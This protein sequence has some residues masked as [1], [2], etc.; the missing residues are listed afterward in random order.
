MMKKEKEEEEGC[1]SICPSG[2]HAHAEDD[3]AAYIY[4]SR[5]L[6]P[7]FRSETG[8]KHVCFFSGG[9]SKGIFVFLLMMAHTGRHGTLLFLLCLPCAR[10]YKTPFCAWKPHIV[11]PHQLCYGSGA[12]RQHI[13]L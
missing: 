9:D 5:Q 7:T 2:A 11:V 13:C 8:T 3:E 1:Y 4:F 12:L 6:G 10:N